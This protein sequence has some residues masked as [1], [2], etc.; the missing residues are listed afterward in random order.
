[1]KTDVTCATCTV[2]RRTE[3]GQ[4]EETKTPDNQCEIR[5]SCPDDGS[6]T[7]KRKQTIEPYPEAHNP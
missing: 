1:M 4:I 3:K 7:E 6:T 2:I 5:L